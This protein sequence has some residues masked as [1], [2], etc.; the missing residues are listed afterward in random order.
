MSKST[1]VF[2]G[3]RKHPPF[4]MGGVALSLCLS[5]FAATPA[6]SSTRTSVKTFES[7]QQQK[8]TIKGVVKDTHGEPVIG[9]SVMVNGVAMAVT[10]VDGNFSLAAAPGAVLQVSYVGF[11]PQSVTVKAG[12][13]N[14]AV[15]LQDD[16]QALNEVVV[17]GYGV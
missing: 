3:I 9:A 5:L 2:L 4:A 17:V 11:K 1:T 15:S 8:Q 16:N 13:T 14:Y 6:L 12:M 10:D 7:T